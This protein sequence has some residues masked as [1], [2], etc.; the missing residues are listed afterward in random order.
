MG[1]IA[2]HERVSSAKPK[3]S[4]LI[5]K[6]IRKERSEPHKLP[7]DF[8]MCMKHTYNK[9]VNDKKKKNFKGGNREAEDN[10]TGK[11]VERT[12]PF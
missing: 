11:V 1:E 5:P 10:I 6:N 2:H 7:S 4:S 8:Y 3:D 12:C 9:Q